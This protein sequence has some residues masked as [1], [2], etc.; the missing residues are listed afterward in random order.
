[1]SYHSRGGKGYVSNRSLQLINGG[2]VPLCA[3]GGL[4]RFDFHMKFFAFIFFIWITGRRIV[5]FGMWMKSL[6][7]HAGQIYVCAYSVSLLGAK[8]LV[9]QTL[10]SWC[11]NLG[12][13]VTPTFVVAS[14]IKYKVYQ[15]E[16]HCCSWAQCIFNVYLVRHIYNVS[17]SCMCTV[18]NLNFV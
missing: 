11:T 14:C 10:F 3:T 2:F 6:R 16:L 4:H 17:P 13:Q 12:M 8:C 5:V 1:M 18:S 15:E 7:N 9:G